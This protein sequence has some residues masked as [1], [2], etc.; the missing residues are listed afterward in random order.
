MKKVNILLILFVIAS[1]FL[2][3]SN[4][5]AKH[6]IS[7]NNV[8]L[9]KQDSLFN[10]FV[11]DTSRLQ[12]LGFS[13]CGT[14]TTT[15]L[16]PERAIEAI[17]KAF[18]EEGVKLEKNFDYKKDGVALRLDGYNKDLNIGYVWL[19]HLNKGE[20]M[21]LDNILYHMDSGYGRF[22]SY[23]ND[24]T[25]LTLSPFHFVT[26]E[27]ISTIQLIERWVEN[28]INSGYQ[29]ELKVEYSEQYEKVKKM[30]DEDEKLYAYKILYLDMLI[31][32][33]KKQGD[34][35]GHNATHFFESRLKSNRDIEIKE[36]VLIEWTLH[37][38]IK[39]CI[40]DLKK[41]KQKYQQLQDIISDIL[42]LKN[43][44]VKKQKY[45]DLLTYFKYRQSYED[46]KSVYKERVDAVLKIK[47]KKR[48]LKSIQNLVAEIS[49][50]KLSYEEVKRLAHSKDKDDFIAVIL[51]ENF[52]H[53]TYVEM[54]EEQK[55]KLQEVQRIGDRKA[56]YAFDEERREVPRIVALEHLQTEVRR[57]IQWAKQQ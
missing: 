40:Y 23:T 25:K 46:Y 8:L 35:N 47:G 48:M 57:Y 32:M 21:V 13:P 17:N 19:Y 22:S 2:R 26:D 36:K 28:Q 7:H 27:E 45:S 1:M 6:S 9:I 42:K 41:N 39:K 10:P 5:E 37:Y 4:V 14:S 38:K 53:P 31:S 52:R 50:S 33:S 43:E 3:P 56:K 11:L 29:N 30:N 49:E 34:R 20:G 55:E 12:S 24:Y 16:P 44:K 51:P 18:E 15:S 54:T